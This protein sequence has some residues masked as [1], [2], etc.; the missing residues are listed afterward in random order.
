MGRQS[1]TYHIDLINRELEGHRQS[2]ENITTSKASFHTNIVDRLIQ[3]L[4]MQA[5]QDINLKQQLPNLNIPNIKELNPSLSFNIPFGENQ[6]FNLSGGL[7]VLSSQPW[8]DS[9]PKN[10]DALQIQGQMMDW[11]INLGIDF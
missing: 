7:N 5:G 11:L 2:M 10:P 1:E 4:V 6:G 3:D 8:F 9:M